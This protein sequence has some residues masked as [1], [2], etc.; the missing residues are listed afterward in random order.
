[1]SL[2]LHLQAADGAT[3]DI[4]LPDPVLN[5]PILGGDVP[6]GIA[7]SS[8]A[9]S[10]DDA[11]LASYIAQVSAS[12]FH[13]WP[14]ILDESRDYTFT[15]PVTVF[16]GFS[17]IGASR[18]VDQ[19]RSSLPIPNRVKLRLTSPGGWLNL[20]NGT[21]FGLHLQGLSFD[22][23][24]NSRVF[25]P[26][27]GCVLWTSVF[28]DISYQNGPGFLGSSAQYQPWDACSFEGWWNLN[29]ITDRAWNLG[30]SDSSIA[31]T[32]MLI[33]SPPTMLGPTGFL[34]SLSSSS[35]TPIANLYVT[36]DQHSALNITGSDS[37]S[38]IRDCV[39][40]GRNSTTPCYGSLIRS[41][42]QFVQLSDSWVS[43]GMANPSAT[44]RDDAGMIHVNGG[45]FEALNLHT[46]RASGV[47]E[48][49]PFIYATGSGTKVVARNIVGEDY[50]GKPVV[51]VLNGAV[52][53]TDGSVTVV[54]V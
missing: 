23:N 30:G 42:G 37:Y 13:G 10:T 11:K 6:Q 19:A 18:A 45:Q 47:A 12:T 34:I 29:N 49:V 9:G 2:I 43:Y 40:E 51:R 4:T 38:S 33:D 39:F 22:A 28:R 48:S 41:S 16:S 8:L 32:R 14:L 20:P 31:P 1:M 52:A 35:K 24:S 50:T 26:N 3:Q 53:D 25:Q 17:I 46:R 27:A 21:V 54:T 15:Q 5:G 7:F 44:G 36:A